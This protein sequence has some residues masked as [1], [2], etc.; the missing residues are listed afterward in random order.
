MKRTRK[1]VRFEETFTLR[2]S[3]ALIERAQ[4]LA[5]ER[6]ARL[7]E[8]VRDALRQH[9]DRIERDAANETQR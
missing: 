3:R 9:L 8:L 4:R 5:A 6:E 2:M 1:T 7:S